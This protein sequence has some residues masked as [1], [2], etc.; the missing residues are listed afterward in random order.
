MYTQRGSISDSHV[1]DEQ[2]GLRAEGHV[3]IES[4]VS[5]TGCGNPP[6]KPEGIFREFERVD[7]STHHRPGTRP[8]LG[9]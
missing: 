3:A 6:E 8:G 4:V 7:S 9:V 2:D 1:F 5:D